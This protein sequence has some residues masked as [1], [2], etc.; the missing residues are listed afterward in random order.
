[1]PSGDA[2]EQREGEVLVDRAREAIAI[3]R[4]AHGHPSGEAVSKRPTAKAPA[5]RRQNPAIQLAPHQ[6]LSR[7]VGAGALAASVGRLSCPAEVRRN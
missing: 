7:R 2:N 4:L 6:F 5:E 1:M 3:W